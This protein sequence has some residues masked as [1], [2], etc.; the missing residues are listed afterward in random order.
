MR[1]KIA[2]D[3]NEIGLPFARPDR[4]TPRGADARRR[5]AEVKVREVHDP[6]TVQL[7]RQ[8]GQLEVELTQP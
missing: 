4:S 5:N 2:G 1:Q 7:R 8:S 6:D 3:R